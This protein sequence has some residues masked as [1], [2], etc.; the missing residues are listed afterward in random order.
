[1]HVLEPDLVA[2][3]VDITRHDHARSLRILLRVRGAPAGWLHVHSPAQVDRAEFVHLA[4]NTLAVACAP[5]F[6][7]PPVSVV[8]CTRE[9]QQSLQR[10]I[11]LLIVLDYPRF[12][13]IIVGNA[14]IS[15]ATE[16]LVATF[17]NDR[18]RYVRE[19]RPGLDWARNCGLAGGKTRHTS[20]GARAVRGVAVGGD[21]GALRGGGGGPAGSGRIAA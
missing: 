2:Q 9:R 12:E 15:D 4:T 21:S 6:E 7:P 5:D 8:V 16:R 10:G 17:A 18:I 3:G 20:R 14:R 11:E 1:M 13:I 19:D